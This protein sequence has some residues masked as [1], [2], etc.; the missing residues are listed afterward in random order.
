MNIQAKFKE[1]KI[2][3]SQYVMGLMGG[4]LGLE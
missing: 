1:A 2:L 4:I 3:K